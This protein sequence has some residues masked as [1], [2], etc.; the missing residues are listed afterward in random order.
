MEFHVLELPKLPQ[1]L[2]EENSDKYSNARLRFDLAHE[3][4]HLIMHANLFTADELKN[5]TIHDKLEYEADAFAACLL[6]PKDTFSQ[7][8]Y[9][10]SINHF[11][12]LKKKWKVSIASMIYRCSDLCILSENQVKYLKDQMT[13]NKYWNHEPLDASVP[14]ETPTAHKQAFQLLLDNEI[15]TPL[16]IIESIGCLP[17]EI[18][19]Y[20]FLPKGMLKPPVCDNIIQLKDRVRITEAT[21]M[22]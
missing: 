16:E 5:K 20:S 3:L 11:I 7:D 2:K 22:P 14:L 9:S 4:G 15:V 19:E 1:E 6:L 12:Q 18:E 21:K 13:S 17:E 8:V 10:T